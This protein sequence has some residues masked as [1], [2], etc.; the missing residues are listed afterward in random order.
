MICIVFS[1]FNCRKLIVSLLTSDQD[2]GISLDPAMVE[3][4]DANRLRQLLKARQREFDRMTQQIQ[5][6]E[7]T[8]ER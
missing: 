2:I 4:A 8:R 1:F 6:L 3:E 5:S 7:L